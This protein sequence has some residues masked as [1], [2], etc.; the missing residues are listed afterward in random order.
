MC[1]AARS[2][3]Q[4][5]RRCGGSEAGGGEGVLFNSEY[6]KKGKQGETSGT[7]EAAAKVW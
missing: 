7:Q 5:G 3:A 1:T 6:G 4:Q 2:P